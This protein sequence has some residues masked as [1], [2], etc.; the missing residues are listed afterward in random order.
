MTDV[1]VS[2]ARRIVFTALAF[3]AFWLCVSASHT[4]GDELWRAVADIIPQRGWIRANDWVPFWWLASGVVGFTLLPTVFVF[5][6]ASNSPAGLRDPHVLVCAALFAGT[7]AFSYWIGKHNVMPGSTWN[8]Y[9]EMVYEQH[10]GLRAVESIATVRALHHVSWLW[11]LLPV[12]PT[13]A[14][15][16]WGRGEGRCGMRRLKWSAWASKSDSVDP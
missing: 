2:D 5:L 8:A 4:L 11:L 14:F 1:Q 7:I 9:L 3:I 6:S 15:V 13:T 10:D 12:I 16:I